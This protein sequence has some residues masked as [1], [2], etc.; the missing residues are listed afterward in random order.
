MSNIQVHQLDATNSVGQW[1]ASDFRLASV[2]TRYGIDFCC[3]GGTAVEQAC[4][5]KGLSVE[6]LLR[7]AQIAS[8]T[9]AIGEQYNQ[10]TIDFLADYIV[11]QFHTYTREMLD[12]IGRYADAVAAAHGAAH[13]ETRTIAAMWQALRE[14]MLAHLRDEEELLFPYIKQ[15]T[16]GRTAADSPA[17]P[18]FGSAAA[19]IAQMGG[20]HEAVGGVLTELAQLSNGYAL[21]EDACNTFRAL[22]GFLPEFEATTKKH[23]HLENN[24]LFPKTI[25]LEQATAG[26]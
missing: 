23:I 6:V 21:P 8:D 18:A 20:E 15:L 19:L 25:K 24:I 7:E 12:H 14:E 5:E 1:V 9:P 4:A 11:N 10:W 2:F 13:P 17:R 16:A 22:Y 3:G 26:E